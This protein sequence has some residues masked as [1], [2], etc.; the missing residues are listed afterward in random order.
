M[1]NTFEG[2]WVNFVEVTTGD[3]KTWL[4]AE[5]FYDKKIKNKKTAL[6]FLIQ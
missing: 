1:D 5:Y 3:M 2:P 6:I 4:E